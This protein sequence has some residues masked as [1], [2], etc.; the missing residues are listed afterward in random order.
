MIDVLLGTK[1]RDLGLES[2][3][4]QD[5]SDG[6]EGPTLLPETPTQRCHQARNIVGACVGGEID[7]EVIA[8]F[9]AHDCVANRTP[10]GVE[11]ESRLV[12]GESEWSGPLREAREACWEVVECIHCE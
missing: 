6:P 8:R 5:T 10:H 4:A 9:D 11:A 7:L 2:V 1:G 12:E 3:G